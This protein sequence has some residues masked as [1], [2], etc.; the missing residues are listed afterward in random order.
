MNKSED[1]YRKNYHIGISVFILRNGLVLPPR[2]VFATPLILLPPQ[3]QSE[4][5]AVNGL[6]FLRETVMQD[7]GI[8]TIIG[9]PESVSKL[10][11][12][13]YGNSMLTTALVYGVSLRDTAKAGPKL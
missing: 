11:F 1:S 10:G 4:I 2:Q 3:F 13:R 7:K 5:P 6:L 8:K 12:S 9:L